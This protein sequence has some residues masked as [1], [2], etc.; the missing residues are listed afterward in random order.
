VEM[1]DI[2]KWRPPSFP[3]ACWKS[4]PGDPLEM[5]EV[6]GNGHFQ[7]S[8]AIS[9]DMTPLDIASGSLAC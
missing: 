8:K 9:T 7:M 3:R 6:S 1:L 4:F 5:E 2:W